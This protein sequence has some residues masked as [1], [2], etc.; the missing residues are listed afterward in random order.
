MK[1]KLVPGMTYDKSHFP[2]A[3]EIAN[4]ISYD[5]VICLMLEESADRAKSDKDQK[6]CWCS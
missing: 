5:Q 4:N 3:C 1:A 6:K 2:K